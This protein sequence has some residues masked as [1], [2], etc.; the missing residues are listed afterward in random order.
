ME[1]SE[2]EKRQRDGEC[3][4][5]IHPWDHGIKVNAAVQ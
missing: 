1:E 3:S 5:V 4:P 2:E